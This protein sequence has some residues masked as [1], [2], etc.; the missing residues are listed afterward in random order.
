MERICRSAGVIFP[1]KQRAF[2]LSVATSASGSR[3]RE[4]RD[5]R[6]RVLQVGR[7]AH[8]GDGDQHAVELRPR[9][10]A[11]EN[12]GKRMAHE[13]ADA[14]LALGRLAGTMGVET[15]HVRCV[16]KRTVPSCPGSTRAIAFR[17]DG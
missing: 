4:R 14:Q 8:L 11:R 16:S 5:E 12:L 17:N 13:L 9:L 3:V 15:G 10:A 7:H 1:R 2:L 6:G